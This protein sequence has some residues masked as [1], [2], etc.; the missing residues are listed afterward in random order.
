ML[1]SLDVD[2]HFEFAVVVQG[3]KFHLKN[4][5]PETDGGS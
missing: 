1:D 2:F 4:Y 5:L 3:K